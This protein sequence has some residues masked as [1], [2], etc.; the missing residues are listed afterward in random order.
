MNE[1][2]RTSPIEKGIQNSDVC[3]WKRKEGVDQQH[4][5]QVN[6]HPMETWKFTQFSNT[7]DTQALAIRGKKSHKSD[8]CTLWFRMNR[9]R[10]R[11][12]VS[13][14]LRTLGNVRYMKIFQTFWHFSV[15][16]LSASATDDRRCVWFFTTLK[17][18]DRA[19]KNW[20]KSST[21][22]A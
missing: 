20:C 3:V 12:D 22:I 5:R 14:L 10:L 15:W 6:L 13:V 16:P 19:Q 8:Q 18:E 2:Y 1:T 17:N 21:Q 4:C 7:M 9:N 11:Q